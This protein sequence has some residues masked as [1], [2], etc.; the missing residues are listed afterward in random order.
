MSV[1]A[2][3]VVRLLCARTSPGSL[4]TKEGLSDLSHGVVLGVGGGEGDSH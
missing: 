4:N 1:R 2:V 3:C